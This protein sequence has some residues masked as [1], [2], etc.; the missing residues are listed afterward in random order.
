MQVVRSSTKGCKRGCDEVVIPRI[1]VEL[2]GVGINS[3]EELRVSDMNFVW[4]D[5]YDWP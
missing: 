4:R 2:R 3:E 5:P 1:L